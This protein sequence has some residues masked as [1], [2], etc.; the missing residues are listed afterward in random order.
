MASLIEQE[1]LDLLYGAIDKLS[2]DLRKVFELSFTQGLKNKEIAEQLGFSV[3][4]V[5]NKKARILM[6]LRQADGENKTLLL[7]LTMMG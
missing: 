2:E 4:T 5:N 1:T 3:K 6:L 7:L